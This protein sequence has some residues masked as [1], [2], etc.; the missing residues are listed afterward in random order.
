MGQR[1][2]LLQIGHVVLEC[3]LLVY[4]RWIHGLG[5]SRAWSFRRFVPELGHNIELLGLGEVEGVDFA[6]AVV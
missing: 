6:D 4:T 3:S 2:H 1:A 5:P